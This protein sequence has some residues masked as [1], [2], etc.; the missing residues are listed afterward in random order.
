MT[1]AEKILLENITYIEGIINSE[2]E[3][4]E[5]LCKK[6]ES[7]LYKALNN[8]KDIAEIFI[9]N[10]KVTFDKYS[11][12]RK[13]RPFDEWSCFPEVCVEN[14]SPLV[15]H[16]GLGNQIAI[17]ITKFCVEEI[18]SYAKS[19]RVFKDPIHNVQ[20]FVQVFEFKS[21]KI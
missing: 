1:D 8:N 5:R 12:G 15:I 21:E 4:G 3:K 20:K 18:Q 9:D 19:H 10:K 16:M 7:A 11:S 13:V 2:K 6:T 17:T 14:D